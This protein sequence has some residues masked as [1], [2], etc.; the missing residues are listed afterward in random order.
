MADPL[1]YTAWSALNAA[2]YAIGVHT[3]NMANADNESYH[4]RTV[5]LAE[6]YVISTGNGSLGTGVNV[7]AV[8]R[9]FSKYV[10]KMYLSESTMEERWTTQAEWLGYV[11]SIFNQSEEKGVNQALA[12]FFLGWEKLSADADGESTRSALLGATSTLLTM[13]TDMADD[14]EQQTELIEGEIGDQVGTVNTILE[15]LADLNA[16]IQRDP[17]NGSLLD[18]RDALIRELAEYMDVEVQYYDSGEVAVNLGTGQPLVSGSKS[19]EIKYENAKSWA[20]LTSQSTFDGQ[21]YFDGESSNEIV[22]K[23]VNPGTADGSGAAAQFRVS[24]DGGQTWLTD[25]NGDYVLYTA[26]SQT[27]AVEVDGVTI[28]FGADDDP[29]GTATG[30][31]AKGDTFTVM[32]K[33]GLYWYKNTSSFENIT[34]LAS[35]TGGDEDERLTGGS[36]TGLFATRDSMIGEYTDKLDAFAESLI[37]EVNYAFSQGAGTSNFSTVTGTYQVDDATAALAESDLHFADKL[38]SGSL[39]IA[40]YDESTGDALGVTSLDF[41]SIIPP[42]TS[43]FDPAVHSLADVAQAINASFGGNVTASVTNGTLTIDAASG[44]EFQFAG[45]T[46]GLLAGL[47]INTY[48]T[49]TGASDIGVNA[50]VSSDVTRINAGMVDASGEVVDGSN[51]TALAICGLETKDVTITTSAGDSSTMTLQ[52]YLNALVSGVGSDSAA[53]QSNKAY[54]AILANE[55]EK[56][57]ESISGV[58]SD[59]ELIRVEQFQRL[60][61]AAANMIEVSNEMF[62]TLMSIA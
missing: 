30:A 23:V 56:E 57:Q 52:E 42:G 9:A 58:N 54:Y 31:L 48:F 50:V 2:Q 12:A 1:L 45:D 26:D 40:L 55:L 32:A 28:W 38:T 27:G 35:S 49:G 59:E 43:T 21:V 17:D 20:S 51:D 11:E 15:S 19:Y 37:W 3:N 29:A 16:S 61:Q 6:S 5:R 22:L 14:L 39:S 60:Y 24:L 44:Y 33:S 41:S 7:A 46:T 25:D 62:E 47:G 13:L 36:L 4:A 10:E 8:N 34:P 18:D 53:A